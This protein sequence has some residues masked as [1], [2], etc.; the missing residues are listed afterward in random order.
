MK[1]EMDREKKK[2]RGPEGDGTRELAGG[3]MRDDR[4]DG[5][6]DEE[7]GGKREKDERI[8]DGEA[9]IDRGAAQKKEPGTDAAPAHDG[10]TPGSREA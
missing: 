10:G 3:L 5:E 7:T 8:E 2:A 1:T 9:G 6:R 4:A